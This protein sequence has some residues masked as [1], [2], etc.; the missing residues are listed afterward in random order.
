MDKSAIENRLRDYYRDM[1][2]IELNQQRLEMLCRHR[3]DTK[4]DIDTSN[5]RPLAADLRGISYDGDK[6]QTSGSTSPQERA[7]EDAFRRLEDR[8]RN[9][10]AQILDTK[11]LIRELEQATLDIGL[12]IG[13]LS[14]ESCELIEMRYK[15]Q[16][17][18]YVIGLRLNVS[19]STVRRMCKSI[20]NALAENI[21]GYAP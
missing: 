11:Q 21:A 17:S 4:Q 12:A 14:V 8:L 7:L 19:E 15:H 1:R 10:D 9:L 2:S 5:I 13:Q 20:L 6:V 3:D 18:G 16:Q